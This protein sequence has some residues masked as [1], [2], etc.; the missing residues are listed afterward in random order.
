MGRISEPI[1]LLQGSSNLG[2]RQA[3]VPLPCQNVLQLV[4]PAKFRQTG[5][6]PGFPRSIQ[7]SQVLM[8]GDRHLLS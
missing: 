2:I 3:N 4:I 8:Q 7:L 6:E 1:P 5:R